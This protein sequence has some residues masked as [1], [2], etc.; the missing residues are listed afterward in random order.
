MTPDSLTSEI[1]RAGLVSAAEEASIVVVRAAHS[2]FVVEGS[3]AS[4]AILDRNGRLVAQSMATTLMHSASLRSSLPAVLDVFALESMREGDIYC[5]NDVYRGGIHAN[6]ILVFKPVFIDGKAEWFTGTLIHVLDLGGTSAAGVSALAS[7][8]FQ[9]GLQLP[10]VRIADATG[11]DD[12]LLSILAANSRAPDATLG[13]LRA[14]IA[15][16]NVAARRLEALIAE[17]GSDRFTQGVDALLRRSEQLTRRSI[18]AIPDGVYRASYP[19][20]DDGIDPTRSYTIAAAVCIEG[21]TA[22]IDFEGTDAQVAASINAGFSQTMSGALFGLRCFLDPTIP[23]NEGC[24]APVEFVIPSGSL[25]NVKPPYPGGGRFFAVFAAVEAIFEAM[26]RAVPGRMIAASGLL[27]PFALEGQRGADGR[28]IHTAF[29]LGGM[30][31]RWG[32]DGVDAVGV[33]HG[34]GRNAIPQSEP[35]ESRHPFVV[36]A[37]ELITDSGGPGRWRGGLGTRTT[38]LLLDDAWLTMR[39]DRMRYPPAGLDGGQP[40]RPGGYF[41]V[42]ADGTRTRLPNKASGLQLMR[43]D[44]FVL[45]TSGGGGL[46]DPRSRYPDAVEQDVLDGRVSRQSALIDYGR[47][48]SGSDP[49]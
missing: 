28:W 44:R 20:D 10:P 12:Q 37:V 23:M 1:L 24:F 11:L 16:V 48:I 8:V 13:D 33:H 34:G 19:I 17:L 6:D 35:L 32:A 5:M 43:G 41:R 7:D 3:D 22:T 39:C 29:E 38:F 26:S 45:E 15:G 21:D 25:L 30:G 47:D 49:S 9:E 14:L 46:G 40:G 36:E 42:S 27:Q 18:S 2:A 31:A 4:A